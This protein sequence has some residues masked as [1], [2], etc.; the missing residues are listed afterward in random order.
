MLALN[1]VQPRSAGQFDSRAVAIPRIKAM[2]SKSTMPKPKAP[3]EKTFCTT[4]EA[5]DLLGV[6]AGT[7]QLWV[8]SGL[9]QAW[10]TAGGHR[11]VVLDSVRLL[12]QNNPASAPPP[13]ANLVAAARPLKIV[14]VDDDVHM[15]GLYQRHL[16]TWAMAPEVILISNAVAALLSIGRSCPDLLVTDLHMPGMDGF[17]MLR[18]LRQ[19]P[20]MAN[21]TIVVASGLDAAEISARGGIPAGIELLAKPVPFERLLEIATAVYQQEHFQRPTLRPLP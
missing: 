6:S 19:T 21:T 3:V 14:V 15:L 10:K 4:R 13:A 16:A 9:L 1:D 7:V 12:L 18:V 5:G 17:N 11:R 8:D 20:E 2:K